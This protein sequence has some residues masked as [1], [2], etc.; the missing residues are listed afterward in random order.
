MANPMDNRNTSAPAKGQVTA[1]LLAALIMGGGGLGLGAYVLISGGSGSQA[2]AGPQGEQGSAG[3]VGPVVSITQPGNNTVISGVVSVRAIVWSSTPYIVK[4]LVNGWEN[5]T[6]LPWQWNTSSPEYG[7]GGWNLTVQVM[8]SSGYVAQDQV[9]VQ[10]LNHPEQDPVYYCA[11][12]AEITAALADIGTGAGKVVITQ[13]ITLTSPIQVNGNGSYVIEGVAPGVTLDCGGNWHGFSITGVASCT[14][15]DLS[16][17]ARDHTSATTAAFFVQE[18]TVTLEHL[19]IIGY[20]H[21]HGTG[22][23]INGTDVWISNCHISDV[24]YGIYLQSYSQAVGISG[25]TISGCYDGIFSHHPS[26]EVIIE[27]NLVIASTYCGLYLHGP[28][29]QVANNLVTG[30]HAYGIMCGN[31]RSTFTG[32][33][34]AQMTSSGNCYGIFLWQGGNVFTDNVVRDI[35]SSSY[36]TSKGY[37]IYISPAAGGNVVAGNTFRY[38]DIACE[39]DGTNNVLYD[40]IPGNDPAY[41]CASEAEITAALA[42]IGTGAGRVVV[43]ANVTLASP[44]QVNGNGSY[45]IEG[46]APGV[47]VDCGGDWEAF[48]I[49]SVASCTVRDLSIDARDH[50][51]ATTAAIFVEESM[52]V[53]E[54]LQIF[55]NNSDYGRGIAINNTNVWVSNCYLCDMY[56]GINLTG[57]SR[58]VSVSGNTVSGCT[59]GLSIHGANHTIANNHLTQNLFMGMWCDGENSTFTGNSV[60]GTTF[61]GDLYGIYLG[62]LADSNVFSGN[63]V[64]DHHSSGGGTGYGIYIIAEADEN[65]VVGN[66]FLYNDDNEENLSATTIMSFN[67]ND[68]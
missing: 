68:P 47:T 48:K 37:G 26:S 14:V 16:V 43:T 15:R 40:N 67:N 30:T 56:D 9:L 50:T 64:N 21:G 54:N 10:V 19:R 52:V 8:N 23:W 29:F 17:D 61:A 13:N 24:H 42:D 35:H 62:D 5:S 41:Y 38:N 32:N 6:S 36:P 11:S 63:I 22:I 59:Y 46:V 28:Y 66:S 27:D 49:T 20:D 45:V 25:N 58:L 31:L 33:T 1:L 65:V 18:T 55:G 7:D 4:V 34:I 57:A 12:Q 60:M 2:P 53:L 51:S 39:D 3:M 44:I